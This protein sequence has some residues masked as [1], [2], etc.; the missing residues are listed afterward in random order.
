MSIFFF[1]EHTIPLTLNLASVHNSQS[2]LIFIIYNMISNK[3][4]LKI[5]AVGGVVRDLLLGQNP[6]D[7]DFLIASGT[8]DDFLKQFPN[9]RP[10]GK[11]Y[12]IF[13]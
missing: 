8:A 3:N 10:V 7:L 9:A 1:I 13:S 2:L 5:L 6:K 11:S 4:N 12:E